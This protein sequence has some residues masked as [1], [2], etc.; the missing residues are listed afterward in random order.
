M[1]ATVC[2]AKSTSICVRLRACYSLKYNEVQLL[3]AVTARDEM[4]K[5]TTKKL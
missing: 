4:S 3:K 2:L 1:I 5:L